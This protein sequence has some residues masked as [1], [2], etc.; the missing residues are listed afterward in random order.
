MKDALAVTK[1]TCGLELL[2]CRSNNKYMIHCD[3][4]VVAPKA[5]YSTSD[6]DCDIIFYF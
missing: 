3:S 2:T 5:L 4:E 6:D 1:R